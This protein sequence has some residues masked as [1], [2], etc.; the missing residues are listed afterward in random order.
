MINEKAVD[1]LISAIKGKD[2]DAIHRAGVFIPTLGRSY[3]KPNLTAWLRKRVDILENIKN[4][5]YSDS[6]MNSRMTTR[7]GNLSNTAD[8]AIAD[9]IIAGDLYEMRPSGDI[10]SE[11]LV[12]II[13]HKF[14][15][16]R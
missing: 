8:E 11:I 9:K 1:T 16:T 4:E 3:T 5:K 7:K 2:I 6:Q 10:N 15:I 12:D 14:A 13:L